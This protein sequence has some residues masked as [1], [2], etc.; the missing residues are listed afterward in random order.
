MLRNINN[1]DE[2]N[3]DGQGGFR[4]HMGATWRPTG[5][6][7]AR[8]SAVTMWW[9]TVPWYCQHNNLPSAEEEAWDGGSNGL[10]DNQGG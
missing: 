10:E 1:P 5:Y 7:G 4:V 3:A 6:R 2:G 8:S 9:M